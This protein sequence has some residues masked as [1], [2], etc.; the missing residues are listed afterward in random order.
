[1]DSKFKDAEFKSGAL[2]IE[3]HR[4]LLYPDHE[5][6]SSTTAI[7]S[8]TAPIMQERGTPPAS[9]KKHKLHISK[10]FEKIDALNSYGVFSANSSEVCLVCQ[11]LQLW[12]LDDA[13]LD[14]SHLR[15]D[16]LD[17]RWCF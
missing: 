8:S 11:M 16:D 12:I 3:G 4:A 15:T 7:L 17:G 1:M 10:M 13:N 2:I 6:L 14:T 5:H 9:I